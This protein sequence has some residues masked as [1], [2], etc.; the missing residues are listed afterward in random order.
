[1]MTFDNSTVRRQDRLL[2]RQRA[3]QLLRT[4]EYGTLSMVDTDGMPYGIPINFVW[5]GDSAIYLHCAPEGRKLRA[6]AQNDHVSF[7]IVGRVNLLPSQFTTEYESVVLAGTACIDLDDDER[8]R[9]LRL[10]LLKLSPDDVELGLRYAEKSLHRTR[11]IRLDITHYSGK[12][13]RMPH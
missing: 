4:A 13:K 6:L 10:L 11:I 8:R 2:D 7:C 3:D 9:A 1:M 12:C 5:D